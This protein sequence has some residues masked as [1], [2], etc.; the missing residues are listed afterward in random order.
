M[1]QDATKQNLPQTAQEL[2]RRFDEGEDVESLGF[3]LSKGKRPGLEIQRTTL[4]LP[5]HIC[6]GASWT[7]RIA[8][9]L[10]GVTRQSSRIRSCRPIRRNSLRTPSAAKACRWVF[11]CLKRNSTGFAGQKT[12]NARS[13]RSL[14]LLRSAGAQ[15]TALLACSGGVSRLLMTTVPYHS[16]TTQRNRNQLPKSASRKGTLRYANESR[17]V[18]T[19][20]FR[21][22]FSSPSGKLPDQLR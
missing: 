1:K 22:N 4:D 15:R 8:P 10:R 12:S 16:Q 9:A 20:D 6:T 5:A 18:V 7:W 21:L 17:T 13:M 3:D 11:C 2:D 14:F 19:V